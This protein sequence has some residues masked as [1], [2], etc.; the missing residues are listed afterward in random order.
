MP[1]ALNELIETR[2]LEVPPPRPKTWGE[3]WGKLFDWRSTRSREVVVNFMPGDT[4]S[5][6]VLKVAAAILEGPYWTRRAYERKDGRRCAVGALRTATFMLGL[7]PDTRHH[8]D[9][10]A[11]D[12]LLQIARAR[13]FNGGDTQ[14][15]EH[16]NDRST[17]QGQVM[18]ALTES[19]ALLYAET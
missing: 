2:T 19:M 3:V 13:G 5:I 11:Y 6:Q 9:R 4:V 10:G 12:A 18:Q 8:C 14:I 7:R 15:I 1:F 17:R 16:M